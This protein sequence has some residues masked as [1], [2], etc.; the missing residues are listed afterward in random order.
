VLEKMENETYFLQKTE[1][2]VGRISNGFTEI[3]GG[4]NL[5]EVIVEGG[6]NL[7]VN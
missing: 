7:Q 5:K 2:E 3:I 1:V 4:N 6:Y